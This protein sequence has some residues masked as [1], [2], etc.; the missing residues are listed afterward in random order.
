MKHRMRSR[1]EIMT[2][3]TR[4]HSACR[5]S[6]KSAKKMSQEESRGADIKGR[7]ASQY[8]EMQNVFV[9]RTYFGQMHQNAQFFHE[10]AYLPRIAANYAT[11]VVFFS[12][13]SFSFPAKDLFS[14]VFR[15]YTFF[16]PAK[17]MDF[18]FISGVFRKWR[19]SFK[20]LCAYRGM[21]QK[22]R[23]SGSF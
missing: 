9:C 4:R 8:R 17:Y 11:F 1:L 2:Q 3:Q 6:S 22:M 14:G 19:N 12:R 16:S 21:M 10:V 7:P 5:N 15:K 20:S 13:F 18:H 23:K